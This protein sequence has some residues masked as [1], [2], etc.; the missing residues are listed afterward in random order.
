MKKIKKNEMKKKKLLE[1]KVKNL[2]DRNK[3]LENN[4]KELK[5]KKNCQNENS[6]VELKN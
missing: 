6:G 2:N 3:K 1:V 5:K 4:L